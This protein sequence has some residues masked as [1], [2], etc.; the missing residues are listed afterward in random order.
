MNTHCG[1]AH[2]CCSLQVLH[3][4]QSNFRLHH[5][6][7]M[8]F[9]MHS[10]ERC[11][12]TSWAVQGGL[13]KKRSGADAVTPQHHSDRWQSCRCMK[14]LTGRW[15]LLQPKIKDRWV[16][17]DHSDQGHSCRTGEPDKYLGT[18]SPQFALMPSGLQ[19][20]NTVQKLI[21]EPR[22]LRSASVMRMNA[23]LSL[24]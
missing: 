23:V 7:P 13:Q 22:P 18:K 9:S 3:Y 21:D 10:F 4:L 8:H 1:A 20:Q 17:L 24:P 11:A 16:W 5:N 2:S 15:V 6:I 14:L 12:T 19:K